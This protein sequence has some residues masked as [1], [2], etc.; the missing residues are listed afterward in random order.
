MNSINSNSRK[1]IL[2]KVA[3]RRYTAL[4][5]LRKDEDASYGFSCMSIIETP[6]EASH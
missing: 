2:F 4:P 1:V 3:G 5:R 6:A